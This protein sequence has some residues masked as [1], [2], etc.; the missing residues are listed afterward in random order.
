MRWMIALVFAAAALGAQQV[1]CHQIF[2]LRKLEIIQEADRLERQKV[3]LADLRRAT[4]RILGNQEAQLTEREAQLQLQL[5]DIRAER[6]RLDVLV[7]RN[8]KIL[9]EIDQVRDDKLVELYT[10][11]RP[12]SAG[13]VMNSMD[14]HLAA[15]ILYALESKIA[16]DIVARMDPANAAQL[17]VILQKG[18]PFGTE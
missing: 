6:E 1:D 13:E 8:Q 7:Q 16:A 15:R 3:E 9:D 2:E 12:S 4:D 11:M 10:Q 5:D 18:P 14:L 17:T